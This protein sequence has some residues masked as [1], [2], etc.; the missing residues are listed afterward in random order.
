MHISAILQLDT[1]GGLK[2]NLLIADWIA[3]VWTWVFA[4]Y[5][6]WG[7]FLSIGFWYFIILNT[8]KTKEKFIYINIYLCVCVQ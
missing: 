8:N 4:S 2:G 6:F 1:G 3:Y 5:P 7:P